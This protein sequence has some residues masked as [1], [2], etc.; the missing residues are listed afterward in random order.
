VEEKYSAFAL[1]Q[2]SD[3]IGLRNSLLASQPDESA[4]DLDI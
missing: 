3:K 1:R 2:A 4:G